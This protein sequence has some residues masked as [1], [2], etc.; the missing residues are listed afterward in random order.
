MT[1]AESIQLIAGSPGKFTPE[2]KYPNN[3]D[4]VIAI[5][6][7]QANYAQKMIDEY[8]D[9][10]IHPNDVWAQSFNVGDILY[11]I[12]NEPKF[13]KQAVYLDDCRRRRV[14]SLVELKQLAQQGVNIIAPPMPALLAVNAANE[15]VPSQ[16]AMDIKAA[17]LDIITWTF[18]RA[19][20]AAARPG[21]AA[22]TR[23]TRPGQR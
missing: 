12:Q 14:L 22:T 6:G 13:G 9:A 8:K 3:P 7:S 5:F 18:E 4:R 2:L 17:G 20:C 1:H 10:G 19:T 23:S 11:W 16:Y 21:S 15:I